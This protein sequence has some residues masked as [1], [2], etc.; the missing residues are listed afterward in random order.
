M[1]RVRGHVN[2]YRIS[3][4]KHA[5]VV[6]EHRLADLQLLGIINETI[7]VHSLK[8]EEVPHCISCPAS[9]PP[10]PPQPEAPLRPS[11]SFEAT[12]LQRRNPARHATYWA[13]QTRLFVR[14]DTCIVSQRYCWC[15]LYSEI[16][17]SCGRA[18]LAVAWLCNVGATQ[19]RV[20]EW[21]VC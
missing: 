14:S 5:W 19:H 13:S 1:M 9:T 4:Q 2:R 10:C 6:F 17:G 21:E 18:R 20:G 8:I 3:G 7:F 15:W 12:H 11:R 16:C